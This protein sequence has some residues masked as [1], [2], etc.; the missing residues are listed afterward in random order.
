MDEASAGLLEALAARVQRSPWLLIATRRDVAGGFLPAADVRQRVELAPLTPEATLALAEATPEAHVVPPHT[1]ELAVQRAAGNPEYLLDLLAAAASGSDTLPDTLE[2]AASARI[3]ALD[4]GDRVLI[5]RAAVLGLTFRPEQ[6]VYVLPEGT[7]PPGEA[8]WRRLSGLFAVDSDGHVRWR[9][10]ALCE[11][12][13][14]RLPFRVRRELHATVGNAL[15]ADVG[16]DVDADPVVLSLHF[17]RAGDHERAW[18]YALMGAERAT[19]VFAHGDAARLYRR[20]V[21]AGR[22]AGVTTRELAAAWEAL[23]EALRQAG[24][25][26]AAGD[27]YTAARRLFAGSPVDEARLCYRHAVAVFRSGSLVSAVRWSHRG[28]RLLEARGDREAK[29]WRAQLLSALAGFQQSQG[30]T[31]D[32]ERTCHEA[33]AVAEEVGELSALAH[34]CYTLDWVLVGSGRPQEATHSVRALAIYRELGDL[35]R[36]SSVLNNLGGLA[37]WRGDWDEAIGLYRRQAESSE[38]AGNPSDAAYTDANI[39]EI[40]SDQGKLDEARERLS[41]ARR[42]WSSTGDVLMPTLADAHLGRLAAR[43]GRYDD[44]L[45]TLTTAAER[46]RRLGAAAD[47]HFADALVAEAEAFGGDPARAIRLSQRLLRISDRDAPLLRRVQGIARARLRDVEGALRELDASLRLARESEADYDI[48]A[49][50][51]AIARVSGLDDAGAHERDEILQRLH[52]VALPA[53]V[54]APRP[55]TRRGPRLVASGA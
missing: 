42:I 14:E 29:R 16:R 12:A 39:G 18:R 6:L 21:E 36:E 28:L 7:P 30:R 31:R 53:P 23:G 5:R 54:L 51:D 27:A 38:R 49:T 46:M 20:A 10:P 2:T 41:R 11:A 52:V 48:A 55:A 24:E 17:S 8:T 22:A 50:L 19:A 1:L 37:Y 47:A 40:L 33:I 26:R 15:E 13:Y 43:E 25:P 32:A 9:R 45:T 44:A 34:A 35:E 3:D 4:P